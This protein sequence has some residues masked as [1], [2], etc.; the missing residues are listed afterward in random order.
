MKGTKETEAWE[1]K[2]KRL[3]EL[4]IEIEELAKQ[5]AKEKETELSKELALEQLRY[6]NELLRYSEAEG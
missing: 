6:T 5:I 2:F 1:A 4:E 3:K